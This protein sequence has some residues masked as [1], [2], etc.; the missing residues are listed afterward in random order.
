MNKIYL[1]KIF[2][3]VT[4]EKGFCRKDFKWKPLSLTGKIVYEGPNLL[5][6]KNFCC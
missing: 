6:T 4:C 1:K 2:I 3:L 5:L